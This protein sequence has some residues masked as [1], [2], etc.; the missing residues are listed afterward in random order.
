MNRRELLNTQ[1]VIHQEK[2][3][4]RFWPKAALP[5][6]SLDGQGMIFNPLF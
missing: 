5:T 6:T 3:N 4:G 1:G 2:L